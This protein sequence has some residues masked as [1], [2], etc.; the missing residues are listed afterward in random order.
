ML[1][2][3]TL[4]VLHSI[5]ASFGVGI[6]AMIALRSAPMSRNCYAGAAIL[7]MV[8]GILAAWLLPTADGW[9]V[10]SMSAMT[11]LASILTLRV[12]DAFEIVDQGQSFSLFFGWNLLIAMAGAGSAAYVALLYLV[13]G[14]ATLLLVTFGIQ[15]PSGVVLNFPVMVGGMV[16]IAVFQVFVTGLLSCRLQNPRRC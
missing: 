7:V 3:D 1:A 9:T 12:L 10:A 16:A 8:T 6:L 5:G 4:Q 11:I 2:L 14:V 13:A 15:P